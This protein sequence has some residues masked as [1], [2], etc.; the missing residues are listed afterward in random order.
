[1]MPIIKTFL[2]YLAYFSIAGG[3]LAFNG[4]GPRKMFWMLFL[5]IG[6]VSLL[7]AYGFAYLNAGIVNEEITAIIFPPLFAL[8]TNTLLHICL[9]KVRWYSLMHSH[10]IILLASAL[11][12]FLAVYFILARHGCE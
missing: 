7:A 4:V 1:M 2:C 9:N 12:P 11:G 5:G 6:I 10:M 3:N 8:A